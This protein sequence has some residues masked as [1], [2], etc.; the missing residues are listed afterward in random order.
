M[1]AVMTIATWILAIATLALALEGAAFL[2]NW[3]T[4]M[5]PGATR[6]ELKALQREVALLHTAAWMDVAREGQGTQAQGDE[7]V[8]N[9]L[10]VD[11]WRPDMEQ[12]EQAGYFNIDRIR[13]GMPGAPGEGFRY[14]GPG[15]RP[16]G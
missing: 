1:L 16:E 9:V 11:G 5:R 2:R 7:K 13:E 10:M 4:D 3:L 8:R 15:A 6:R 14:R 12:A